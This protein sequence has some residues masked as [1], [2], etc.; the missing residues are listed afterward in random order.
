MRTVGSF[1]REQ[2]LTQGLTLEMVS[3]NTRISL[4]NLEAIEG[5]E[6][7]HFTSP[8]FYK[9][10]VKQFAAA[11]QLDTRE[12]AEML[13]S[14]AGAIPAPPVPGEDHR[15]LPNVPALRQARGRSVTRWA[16]PAATLLVVLVGCSGIYAWW[17]S[18]RGTGFSIAASSPSKVS[19]P[20]V[21]PASALPA[22]QS[23]GVASAPDSATKQA[24]NVQQPIAASS[25][26]STPGAIRLE[27]AAVERTWVSVISDGKNIYSGIL[28][29]DQTK[30]F[31]GHE[32]ARIKAGNAAGVHI[33]FNGRVIG[34]IGPRGQVRTAVFT[35]DNFEIVDPASHFEFTKVSRITE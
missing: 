33:V 11:L 3:R 16:F 35:P 13:G 8:F 22:P 29:P 20:P 32:S 19:S 27:L 17:E 25:D 28:D 1:L 15:T 31:E 24:P 23:A 10:F 26:P 18:A 2:R 5:D 6:L 7:G 30:V 21:K 4:G 34:A 9:S 14:Q 12:F